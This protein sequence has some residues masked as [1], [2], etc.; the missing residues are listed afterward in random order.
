MAPQHNVLNSFW[1]G[2]TLLRL[3]MNYGWTSISHIHW[4][5]CE[6]LGGGVEWLPKIVQILYS[7]VSVVCTLMKQESSSLRKLL[8]IYWKIDST[9]SIHWLVLR[10][11]HIKWEPRLSIIAFLF[12]NFIIDGF[13]RSQEENWRRSGMDRRCV[14]YEMQA[15]KNGY[16]TCVKNTVTHV[17]IVWDIDSF[18]SKHVFSW[19]SLYLWN[20]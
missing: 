15:G 9:C 16:C 8:I 5:V 11:H 6:M 20:Q 7:K 3:N 12:D 4:Y 17:M 19:N 18:A 1:L 13:S 2:S 14:S 10:R